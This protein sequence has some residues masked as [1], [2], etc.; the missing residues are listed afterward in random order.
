MNE[1]LYVSPFLF[2]PSSFSSLP[3]FPSSVAGQL[4]QGQHN[5][6]QL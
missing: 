4:T 2:F 1:L 6:P 5:G 3:F